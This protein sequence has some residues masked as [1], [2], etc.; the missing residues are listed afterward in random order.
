VADSGRSAADEAFAM[1]IEKNFTRVG[2]ILAILSL[3][4][5]VNIIAG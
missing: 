2:L 3:L 5:V 4:F 1:T